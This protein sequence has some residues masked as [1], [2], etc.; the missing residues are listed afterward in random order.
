MLV[1]SRCLIDAEV[2]GSESVVVVVV[3]LD[4]VDF[5]GEIPFVDVKL[6]SALASCRCSALCELMCSTASKQIMLMSLF[7]MFSWG[8]SM[9]IL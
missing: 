2:D 5:V 6:L 3:E 9:S 7:S 4:V 1:A 8:C